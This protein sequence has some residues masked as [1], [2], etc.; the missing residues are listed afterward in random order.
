MNYQF[1]Y[2]AVPMLISL[3]FAPTTFLFSAVKGL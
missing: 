1:L 3:A 2:A